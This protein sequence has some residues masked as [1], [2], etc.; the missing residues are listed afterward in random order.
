MGEEIGI[1]GRELQP[2]LIVLVDTINETIYLD[3]DAETS[4]SFDVVNLSESG[5]TID[6]TISAEDS[7]LLSITN[8]TRKVFIPALSKISVDS[9]IVCKGKFLPLYQSLGYI[10]IT[11]SIHGMMLEKEHMIQVRVKNQVQHP[12]P[13]QIKIFDGRSEELSLFKYAWNQWNDP[14]SSGVISE[15]SGNGNGKAEMGE[16]F[17]IWIQAP[18]AFDSL[19]IRTWHP[20]IPIN[21]GDNT[22]IVVEKVSHHSFNTGRSILSAQIRLNRKPEKNDPVRIPLQSEFLKIEPLVDDCH[23]N[24]ADNFENF[25][26]E[27]LLY[28]DGTAGMNRHSTF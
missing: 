15:G 14:L 8:R 16:T 9:L 11:S 5:Q 23:R 10:R 13:S 21:T 18:F 6:F 2:P 28:E 20:A 4:L 12:D 1:A 19:D 22:D 27:I 17:S 26:Y 3:H 7:V 24:V 25:Y